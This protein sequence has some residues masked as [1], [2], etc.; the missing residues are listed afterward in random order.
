MRT[1]LLPALR[2][3]RRFRSAWREKIAKTHIGVH[4]AW[5]VLLTG[6]LTFTLIGVVSWARLRQDATEQSNVLAQLS[7]QQVA[8]R[9]DADARLAEARLS[10]LFTEGNRQTRYLSQR[11]DIVKAIVSSNN[12]A[13][14]AILAPA[15]V[16]GELDVLLV[17]SANG[18]VTGAS[19]TIDLLAA[20]EALEELGLREAV[21]AVSN[22][23]RRSDR[24]AHYATYRLAEGMRQALGVP[25]DRT[26]GHVSIEPV[27]DDFGDVAGT[28]VGLRTLAPSES[29][30]ETFSKIVEAGVVVFDGAHIVTAG[31]ATGFQLS[32]AAAQSGDDLLSDER[33]HRV[34]RCVTTFL[35]LTICTHVDA[36]E[37]EETQR[38]MLQI[39]QRQA[40]SLF[41]WFLIL[42]AASLGVLV[43]MV[44]LGV[45]RVTRGLPQLAAAA[46]SVSR[47]D[48]DKPFS[49]TGIGEVRSLG[50]AF[51]V[52]ISNLR[53]S[54][55]RI[56]QL[57]FVDQVTGLS[58]RE[59]MRIDGSA[60]LASDASG[61]A[62]LFVDLDRFK[63]IN[64]S[65]GHK[66]GDLLL[67][68]VACRLDEFLALYRRSGAIDQYWG[69]RLGGD[70]FLVIVRAEIGADAV[71]ACAEA[72][73][74]R[75]GEM[76][77]IGSA[78]VTVGASIGIA[79]AGPAGNSYDDLL[80]KADMA[81]YEAKRQGRGSAA[82]FTVQ[83]AV[84]MQERLALEQD[85]RVALRDGTLDV[86]YQPMISLADGSVEAGEALA[87]WTH[88][89]RGEVSPARFI[90]IAEDAGLIRE[91]GLFV[92]T[93]AINEA[94]E[95]EAAG[96][97]I[98]IAVN[99]SVLQ[100]ED[101]SFAS[102]VEALLGAARL[103]PSLLELEITE[104]VAMRS[105]QLVEQQLRQLRASGIRFAIDDFGT[106]YSNLSSLAR[107]RVDTL[108][109]DR[110]L[111]SHVATTPEQ[112]AI[113]RTVLSL[114]RSLG[115]ATVVEGVEEIA[116]LQFMIDEG[117]H[118]AQGYY[119]S[120][121][122]PAVDFRLFV[123]Q[124]RFRKS[125]G[126]KGNLIKFPARAE[127]GKG[128]FR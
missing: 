94:R 48:L 15:S 30:F 31:G 44:L 102:S 69:G 108:K 37:V 32:S 42:A 29:T 93:R 5:I 59:K 70:E 128:R 113:V 21:A 123:S 127:Q 53:E 10:I 38:E 16:T 40:Y 105:S 89:T 76:Y 73:I 120:P 41:R 81:M 114:A 83:T 20:A 63:S 6:A 60:A 101:P 61:L 13:I 112:Q 86:F 28:L 54:L 80:I 88:P 51:E 116:D 9:L 36:A 92:L 103:A 98:R 50:R 126:S 56:R 27:F 84:A 106:G 26:I 8:K 95:L 11:L 124:N 68:Q 4:L 58:N 33:G 45:R 7:R 67:R 107:L 46:T 47:G 55:G 52:M 87:R 111:V 99:V 78:H 85:L 64:D 118:V 74:R 119:F 109:I 71:R 62:F 72:L 91:L 43:G 14:E 23:N 100:L 122:L 121:A 82:F 22:D 12:V 97:P 79:M 125:L 115:F 25:Q 19:R 39:S 35:D 34:A 49:A 57:A 104:T 18:A 2:R 66:M 96:M 3:V 24:K 17:A 1:R 77:V 117:A 110:S 75:L 90:G 65:F